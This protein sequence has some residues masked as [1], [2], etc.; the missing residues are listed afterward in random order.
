[1]LRYQIFVN[2]LTGRTH[3]LQVGSSSTVADVK[4][5]IQSRLGIPPDQAR[6]IFAGKQLGY[7][8]GMIDGMELTVL[9]AKLKERG[10]PLTGS[11]TALQQRYMDG[12][13]LSSY[14]IEKGST[15]HLVLRLGGC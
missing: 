15:L 6:L 8:C 5:M 7:I 12:V 14:G 9:K 1:M 10:L 3:A 11:K 4:D 13:T 2:T